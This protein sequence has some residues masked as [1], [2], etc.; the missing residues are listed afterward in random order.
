VES[1]FRMMGVADAGTGAAGTQSLASSNVPII[2]SA[3][4]Q[5]PNVT[6][7]IGVPMNT[8]E[9]KSLY[10][11]GLDKIMPGRIKNAAVETSGQAYGP[12][13]NRTLKSL[14]D[15][16]VG[17]AEALEAAKEA[18]M[19]AMKEA[20]N[21]GMI[22][23]FGPLAAAG[24][25]VMGLAGG[26][27]TPESEMPDGYGGFMD[28]PGQRLLDQYPERYA[29]NF[30]GVKPMGSSGYTTYTPAPYVPP[31]YNA[32][33]GSGPAGVA[34]EFPRMDGPIN[35]PGTGTS[36]DV[37]AMLSDG[38]FV[39]TAKAVRNMGQGSRRKGAK[40]MYALMKKLEGTA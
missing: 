25:G 9:P 37:P 7:P 24:V 5:G 23:K 29:L 39:F 26:F 8:V 22:Q 21:P 4:I 3:G 32:A 10:Q 34:Q 6:D 30:G 40:K 12:A 35:G 11:R 20:A 36:D 31:T 27:D 17:R 1:S 28:A 16:G 13:Y 2:E 14:Q 38:E 19:A 15:A 18:G 33:Q